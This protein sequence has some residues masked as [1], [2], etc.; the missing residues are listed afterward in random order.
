M[1]SKSASG[2][3]RLKILALFLLGLTPF[4]AFVLLL[5]EES[6]DPISPPTPGEP[7][8]LGFP[9]AQP[10]AEPSASAPSA[11]T[12]N[13]SPAPAQPAPEAAPPVPDPIPSEEPDYSPSDPRWL[14]RI[15][16]ETRPDC[17]DDGLIGRLGC[18]D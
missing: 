4:V 1:G 13:V 3:S 8:P 11:P 6:S 7:V 17:S 18:A 9:Y 12:P 5:P 2:G 10:S 14:E 15:R 16:A